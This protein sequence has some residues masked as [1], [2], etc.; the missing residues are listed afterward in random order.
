MF[1]MAI[2]ARYRT[3]AIT[4]SR[5]TVS[6]TWTISEEM[7][8]AMGAATQVGADARGCSM[9]IIAGRRTAIQTL[10][11]GFAASE[12]RAIRPGDVRQVPTHEV[13]RRQVQDQ[14][15]D[16]ESEG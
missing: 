10:G 7:K 9:T 2:E 12:P 11:L 8:C 13:R 4:L 6:I 14:H 15:T 3:V 1:T 5:H 16:G